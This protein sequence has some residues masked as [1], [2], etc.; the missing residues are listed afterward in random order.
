[1]KRVTLYTDGACSGN[2]GPGGYGAILEYGKHSRELSAGFR[3]TTNNRME[4]MAV[5]AGLSALKE[6]CEVTV[7]SDSRYVVD[8][9]EKGWARKWQ[10]NR[11]M[12][13]K[14]EKALN[15]D[16]WRRLL[17]LLEKHRVSFTWIRGHNDQ[18]QNER[19]DRLA[20]A[21]AAQPNL[22]EDIRD[23]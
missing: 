15:V 13:N 18:P 11:W 20:V 8:A 5:I 1:M 3:N 14:E 22:P 12:R 21:A 7:V 2:P 6:P 16:L 23:K 9:I 17:E 4:M 19:C 10:A